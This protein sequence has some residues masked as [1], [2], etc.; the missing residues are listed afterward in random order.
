MN[1]VV[2]DSTAAQSLAKSGSI[3]RILDSEGVLIG[4]FSPSQKVNH[5]AQQVI[6]LPDPEN[7]RCNAERV[8]KTYTTSE[9]LAHLASLEPAQ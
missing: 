9:V 2:L 5:F 6:G 3:V 7:V 1:T 8:E 4:Y